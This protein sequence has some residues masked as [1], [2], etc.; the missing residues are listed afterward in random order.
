MRCLPRRPY[1]KP[2]NS[3][4]IRVLSLTMKPLTTTLL[5]SEAA[6]SQKNGI[7]VRSE[8]TVSI[9]NVLM[10]LPVTFIQ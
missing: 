7:S 3:Q 2:F 10:F 5:F 6:E 9:S 4:W 1:Q 8:L